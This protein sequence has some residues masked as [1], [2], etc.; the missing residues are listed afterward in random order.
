MYISS[1]RLWSNCIIS[2]QEEEKKWMSNKLATLHLSQTRKEDNWNKAHTL[3]MVMFKN[4]NQ[5]TD[6]SSQVRVWEGNQEEEVSFWP[7]GPSST[8][9]DI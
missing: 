2:H 6:L 8:A 7:V 9:A 3:K 1:G 5:T 4:S